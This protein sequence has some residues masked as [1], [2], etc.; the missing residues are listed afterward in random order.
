MKFKELETYKTTIENYQL[1]WRF[2]SMKADELA[3]FDAN[4]TIINKKGCEKIA[5]FIK[6]WNLHS[7][8]PFKKDLFFKNNYFSIADNTDTQIETKL[9]SLG[10][11]D[12]KRFFWIG[13]MKQLC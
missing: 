4:L 2:D 13:T 7:D 8:F 12:T 11:E 9:D 5:G 3:H 1:K 10:F 6:N